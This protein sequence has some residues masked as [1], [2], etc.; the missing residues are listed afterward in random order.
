MK[1]NGTIFSKPQQDQLKRGIGEELN[2]VVAMTKSKYIKHSYTTIN[3]NTLSEIKNILQKAKNGKNI[4]AIVNNLYYQCGY[5]GDTPS[6]AGVSASIGGSGNVT[7]AVISIIRIKMPL[8][9]TIIT[10]TD[11]QT[12]IVSDDV[13]AID[14]FEEV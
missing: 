13:T 1:I 10:A 9:R 14:I 4:Y 12:T 8:K 2:K 11:G 6:I 7:G 5:L 3:D